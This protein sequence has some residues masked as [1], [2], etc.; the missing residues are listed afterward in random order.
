MTIAWGGVCSLVPKL[1][2]FDQYPLFMNIF[3][4]MVLEISAQLVMWK[5]NGGG[6]YHYQEI[7]I[8]AVGVSVLTDIGQTKDQA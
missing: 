8:T 6:H 2:G 4:I 3:N 7:M 5:F 1:S